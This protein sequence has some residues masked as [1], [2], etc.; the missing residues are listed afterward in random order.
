MLI[1]IQVFDNDKKLIALRIF[2][3]YKSQ[4]TGL[5]ANS[6]RAISQLFRLTLPIA[7][8]VS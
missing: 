8:C 1:L 6:A 3:E 2:S 7:Q 5:E 4:K